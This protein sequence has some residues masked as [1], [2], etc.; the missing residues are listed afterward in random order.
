MKKY[1]FI[2]IFSF[3]AISEVSSQVRQIK[4]ESYILQRKSHFQTGW[5]H[6]PE[7]WYNLW[8]R[9]YQREYNN[10]SPQWLFL[11]AEERQ[12]N[13]SKQKEVNAADTIADKATERYINQIVDVAYLM[14]YNTL[15]TLKRTCRNAMDIYRY[16]GSPDSEY[17]FAILNERYKVLVDN[18][19][20]LNVS[21]A[22]SAEKREQYQ[23]V[24]KQFIKLIDVTK[25]LIRA[26][27][28]INR[29]N[30]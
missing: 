3:I 30:N 16:C 22:E 1:L 12:K 7:W 21:P 9:R 11:N 24:E 28:L 17:N 27:E 25:K 5:E 15:D 2:L 6:S 29:H 13:K 18:I 10:N 8:Y 23:D 14:E 19:N 26:N 4:D 20:A